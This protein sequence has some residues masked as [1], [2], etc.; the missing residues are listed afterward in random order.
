MLADMAA[1]HQ[2]IMQAKCRVITEPEKKSNQKPECWK[3]GFCFCST[4]GCAR[5]GLRT[6]LL[7]ALKRVCWQGSPNHTLLKDAR[8]LIHWYRWGW[9]LVPV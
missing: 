1:K 8:V 5:W 7:T 4:E 3:V 9:P 6:A 2:V